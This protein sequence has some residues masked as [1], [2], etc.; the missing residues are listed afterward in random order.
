MNS[1]I[2]ELTTSLKL[3]K[4]CIMCEHNKGEFCIKGS[5]NI[6]YCKQCALEKFSSLDYLEKID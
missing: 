6:R 1:I 2:S 5:P 3:D 4:N